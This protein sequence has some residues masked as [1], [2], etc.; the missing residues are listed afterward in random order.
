MER[1]GAYAVI[2]RRGEV[3]VV[4]WE[5][6]LYLPGGGIDPQEG[7]FAAL[8]PEC[9][10]ECLEETGWRIR[11]E[12]RLSAF[13]RRLYASD[14]DLWLRKTCFIYLCASGAPHQRP[15]SARVPPRLDAC[16]RRGNPR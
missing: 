9:L 4:Q 14:V 6:R 1:P 2:L 10:P 11:V 12:R 16:R 3:L 8:H 5:G 13:Q 15:Y 7:T